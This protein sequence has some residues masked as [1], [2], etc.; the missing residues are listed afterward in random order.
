[1]KRRT[2]KRE[3]CKTI[4]FC[5]TRGLPA[6][7][8]GFETAVDHITRHFVRQGHDCEVFC[9]RSSASTNSDEHEGRK[10]TY[11][12]GH[13]SPKLDTF[14]A[15]I[16]TGLHL[17]KN[18]RKYSHVFWFNNA[19]LPGILLT[20]LARIPMTVNTDGLEWRR[21]KWSLPFKAYYWLSSFLIARVC[22]SL[23]SDSR[24]IQDY[25]RKAFFK[26][27]SFIP[28]GAPSEAVVD[29]RRARS[30]LDRYDLEEGAYFLQIT[31]IEPDNL[32]LQVAQSFVKSI[33]SA[34]GFKMVIVGYKEGTPYA[35]RLMACDARGGVIV[36]EAIYDPDVL[37]VLR[38][39]CFC[40][41]HGNSVG[42]TNP[43]L[44]EAMAT[45]PRVI[46]IDCVFSREVLGECGAYFNPENITPSFD[47]ALTLPDLSES[48]RERVD[49]KYKWDGV[50]RSYMNLAE[51][52]PADYRETAATGK[53]AMN[54]R[55]PQPVG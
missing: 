31:R 50:A 36:R 20:A 17:W 53:S 34:L 10:L 21:A 14:V 42:G 13:A 27:T 11:V 45:T 47:K 1:M 18:R 8:G 26:R 12:D 35:Q 16:Q 2:T 51:G 33:P 52:R 39:N 30:I 44:L 9:R 25:Y 46:A 7:Y 49:A 38:N 32:P 54:R 23:V 48:M 24:G 28:Y 15:A 37:Q 40:Y 29:N 55:S 22:R 3:G 19:N 4:A 41:V 6:N 5:G 43:A